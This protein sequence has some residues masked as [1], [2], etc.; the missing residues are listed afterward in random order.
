MRGIIRDE[1]HKALAL[2]RGATATPMSAGYLQALGY[3]GRPAATSATAALPRDPYDYT[4][5]FGPGVP[6]LPAPLDPALGGT[7][8]PAPRLSEYPVSANLQLTDRHVPWTVLRDVADQVPLVRRCIEVRKASLVGMEWAFTVDSTRVARAAAAEGVTRGEVRARLA[9]KHADTIAR[10]QQFWARPDRVSGWK[11]AQWLGAVIEEQ[12]VLDAVCVYPHPR[13]NG[14]LH[15]LELIDGSTIKP[16]IDY[17][18]ATPQPPFAAYQQVLQGFP[19]GEFVAGEADAEFVSA[20]YGR[21][22]MTG[23]GRSDTLI[24]ERRYTRVNSPYGLPPTEQALADID[25]WL[26]RVGWLKSEYA[27]GVTPEMIVRVDTP[28][29]PDQLKAY[30]AVFN[31]E[32]QGPRDSPQRHRARFLPAGFTE[33]YPP[34]M[35]AKF[36]SDLD[37]HLMRLVCNDFDVL[38][39]EIGIVPPTGLGGKGWQEGEENSA[40]RR[41]ERPLAAWLTDLINDV[42][43]QW[44]GMPDELTFQFL[45]L[46]SED[47]ERDA[48]IRTGYINSGQKTLNEG[49]D[50]LNLPRYQFDLADQPYVATGSGPVYFADLQEQHD[51]PDPPPGQPPAPP[52]GQNVPPPAE[53]ED[54]EDEEQETPAPAAAHAEAAKFLRYARRRTGQSWRDFAFTAWPAPIATTANE[55]ARRGDLDLAKALLRTER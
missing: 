11:F 38:P 39:S 24:Y 17:R 14:E 53:D 27:T 42:S 32:L 46:E 34:G 50:E 10:L 40:A 25:L 52:P 20:V 41:G 19:R 2:P 9:E 6:L 30:E 1:L 33:S 12:M 13:M 29:T 48:A 28:M 31:D 47:E 4:V 16:L 55:L 51:Q 23:V 8:R 7:G 54:A 36:N 43:R 45:G 35:E 37:L 22:N 3:H 18:G 15:S 44:L 49:R 21:P 26:L 5:G